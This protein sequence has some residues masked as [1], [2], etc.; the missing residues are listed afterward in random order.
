MKFDAV[1]IGG[2]LSGLL[3]GLALNQ[4]GLSCAIVSRGQSG[5]FFASGSLDLLSAL[6]DGTPVS[7]T[8]AGLDALARQ[9]PEH[10]YVR[11][12]T[13]KVMDYAR[14]A[15]S[16]LAESGIAMIGQ[17]EHPHQRITPLGTRRAAWLS[18]PEVPL[19]SLTGQR[20]R[21]VGISGFA[22]FQ[23]QLAAAGLAKE[24][25][26]VD[27]A[28]IILPELDVLRDN[29][30]EFRSANIARL[31]ETEA[32]WTTLR[33]ALLPQA[34][35][36]DALFMPA[37]FGL[38]DSRLFNW[39]QRE[40]PC[41]L[42]LLPTLPPSVP[43]MRIH[44][45][46]QRQF[47]KTGGIWMAGDEVTHIEHQHGEVT[48]VRTRNHGDIALRPRF[49]VLASGS[50]FSNG[51]IASRE[52]I[53]ETILGLDVMQ[54]ASRTDWYHSDFF[55]PQPWQQFGVTTDASL[56]PALQGQRF[57]NLF[58]TGAVLGGF[59]PIAQG[60]GGGVCA[61]TALHVAQQIVA[62]GAQ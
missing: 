18:P 47:I 30:T 44:S 42:F 37:C 59:D 4:H 23:P 41:P 22:D 36:A 57:N 34:L 32:M 24:G 48:A 1:I 11:I 9:A 13:D 35:G 5:L 2:G 15:Q 20:I 7:D 17:P 21:V 46:L 53:R 61:V 43:G 19:G 60:C 8:G 26:R 51:L 62:G 27:T 50:F 28:E 45:Q 52:G 3:C 58:A 29:P 31:L 56:R 55:Q 10:P 6:P 49:T 25:A 14:Q 54:S 12:G 38:N 16:L 40:L 39:L 33:D